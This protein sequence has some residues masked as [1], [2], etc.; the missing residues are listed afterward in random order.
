MTRDSIHERH[1]WHRRPALGAVAAIAMVL[2]AASCRVPPPVLESQTPVPK[3]F[4]AT[5]TVAAPA[6]WWGA[7]GDA[8]LNALMAR[9]LG[10]N[11]D[12]LTAWDR[13]AQ[14]EALARRAGADIEPSLTGDASASR[15]RMKTR[16]GGTASASE[17]SL[18]LR[19]S[20]EVDL[21]GRVRATRDAA[22]LAAQASRQDVDATALLLSAQVASTWY[23]LL[24]QLGQLALLDE[25]IR[26]NEKYLEVMNVRFRSAERGRVSAVD[27]L[28]QEQLVESIHAEKHLAE[29]QRQV[30]EHQLAVLL[31]ESP[32]MTVS[33]DQ[34]TLPDLPP[35]PATGVPAELIRRRP[36]VRAAELRLASA[37]QEVAAAV[38]D[39]F[40]A[41]SLTART[42]AW[43][44]RV[45]GLFDNWLASIAANLTAPILDGGRLAAEVDRTRAAA[46]QALHA[47]GQAALEAFQEV[48]DALAKEHQQQ[49]YLASVERQLDL[50]AKAAQETQNRYIKGADDYLRLLT[51]VQSLQR[52]QRTQLTAKR[53][54]L[55]YRI[56]LCRALGGGW[57]LTRPGPAQ[58]RDDDERV[59]P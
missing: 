13:L 45:R 52:L 18:G 23:E 14:A 16:P 35:Q 15:T 30:L 44:D 3:A 56:D 58:T 21:W 29:L 36:D 9:A 6:Q 31:G 34:A 43:G 32:D 8:R 59:E 22:A 20:Y 50:A 12:L 47:Y 53:Q 25:Q 37:S 49:V 5:G 41:L 54:L 11:L 2:S 27:I 10:G 1:L 51:A 26:T 7:F 4:S 28:Q 17:L 39:R 40:P 24:D 55:G 57:E 33:A 48:E 19:A 42:E 38:A 46:A